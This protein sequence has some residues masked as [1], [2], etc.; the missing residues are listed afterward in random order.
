MT[1]CDIWWKYNELAGFLQFAGG[2]AFNIGIRKNDQFRCCHQ[3]R[4]GV[5][6][7]PRRD[8]L[9]QLREGFRLLGTAGPHPGCVKAKAGRASR[10]ARAASLLRSKPACPSTSSGC[11]A[12]TPRT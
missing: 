6:K 2:A 4:V 5:P 12:G 7:D 11:R 3:A 10:R 9:A 1:V 8:L